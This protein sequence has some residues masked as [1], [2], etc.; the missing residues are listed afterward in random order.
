MSLSVSHLS[1]CKIVD[2]NLL[3]FG[4]ACEWKITFLLIALFFLFFNGCVKLVSSGGCF[5]VSKDDAAGHALNGGFG[6]MS[7]SSDWLASRSAGSVSLSPGGTE[8]VSPGGAELVS[9]GDAGLV[10][11]G[12]A[13]LV[14]PGGAELV[15]H[16]DAGL[17]SNVNTGLTFNGSVVRPWRSLTVYG[18]S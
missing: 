9:P 15:S 3:G 8:L 4:S 5:L 14:L 6:F 7:D 2:T 1:A 11:H 17:V 18:S 13:G 10:S 12:D 16:G